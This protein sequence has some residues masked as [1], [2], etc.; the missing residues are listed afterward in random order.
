MSRSGRN[1]V[2]G[3]NIAAVE[4]DKDVGRSLTRRSPN[5]ILASGEW[6]CC[7]SEAQE[8]RYQSGETMQAVIRIGEEVKEK[9][10]GKLGAWAPE[11]GSDA[12]LVGRDAAPASRPR[13]A[14]KGFPYRSCFEERSML[15][16]KL[17]SRRVEDQVFVFLTITGEQRPKKEKQP[18]VQ[19]S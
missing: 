1:L 6:L 18:G 10:S 9:S 16:P 14:H 2:V 15:Q 4:S 7:G 5:P 13:A 19:A 12:R 17:A 8:R 11:S 3:G